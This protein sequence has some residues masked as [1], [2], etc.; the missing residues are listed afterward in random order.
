MSAQRT[1][2]AF[3]ERK[4]AAAL[5][6]MQVLF[7]LALSC[8]TL[9]RILSDDEDSEIWTNAWCAAHGSTVKLACVLPCRRI[10]LHAS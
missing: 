8:K 4:F 3:A 7:H 5:T 10:L 1:S 9:N 6:A 2:G